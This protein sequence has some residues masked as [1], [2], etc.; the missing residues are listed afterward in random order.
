MLKTIGIAIGLV[1]LLGI[2]GSIA[3]VFY[4]PL[5]DAGY[6]DLDPD[7]DPDPTA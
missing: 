4:L 1:V 6:I 5:H 7:D 2:V 3:L